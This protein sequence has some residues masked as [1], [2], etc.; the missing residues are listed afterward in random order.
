M[1]DHILIAQKIDEILWLDWDP[2]GINDN[3]QARDEYKSYV[4]DIYD[5]KITCVDRNAIAERLFKIETER[6]SL[7][8][9]RERCRVIADKI[10]EFPGGIF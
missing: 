3:P 8:G 2:V 5:F 10:I 9:N 7:N 1:S 4:L 6:I